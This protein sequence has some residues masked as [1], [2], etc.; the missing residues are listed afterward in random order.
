[1]QCSGAKQTNKSNHD[2]VNGHDEVQELGHD[3]DE[4]P[5]QEGDQGRQTEVQVH[6]IS[7]AV[8]SK[9]TQVC[10]IGLYP[11]AS[12]CVAALIQPEAAEKF[13]LKLAV[14]VKLPMAWRVKAPGAGVLLES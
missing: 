13:R 12:P 14:F 8:E 5:R 2:Q 7:N 3:Q 11:T 6:G 1:V 4:D 10:I 9:K